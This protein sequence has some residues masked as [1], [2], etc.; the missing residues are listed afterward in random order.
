MLER[1]K[2]A[3]V[4]LL[5]ALLLPLTA[6]VGS[7]APAVESF[8]DL[9]GANAVYFYHL[10]SGRAMGSKNE[11]EKLPA[12]TS[13]RI[14]SGLIFCERLENQLSG[15]V[16]IT[17]DMIRGA[18]GYYGYGME[19]G[20]FFRIE[21]LLYLSLCG[22]YN[23]AYYALAYIIGAGDISAFVQMMNDRARELGAVNTTATDPS[24]ILDSS[25]TTAA[26]LLLI[27]QKTVENTLYM[28]I[29]GCPAYDLNGERRIEN[30]NALISSAQEA[31]RYYN[32]KCRGLTA[33]NT[34]LGGWTVVTMSEKEND[35]YLCIVL[36]GK[37]GQDERAEK[38]GY[39]IINRMIDWGYTNYRY[40]EVLTPET[41]VCKI[42]VRATDVADGAQLCVKESLSFYLPSD[43]VVGENVRFSI[44]LIHEELDAPVKAGTHVGYIA[45]IYDEEVLGT[46]ML[47]TAE[48]I[49]RS[50]FIGGLMNVKRLTESRAACAGLIFFC[51]AMLAWGIGEYLIKRAR[52][53]KWDRYFSEKIDAS[54]TFLTKK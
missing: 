1:V 23:D 45:V 41:E 34:T 10:E 20:D 13:L 46:A 19:A 49:G 54:E 7:A 50:G 24:G 48:D 37:V 4:V 22:G 3:A 17:D 15:T 21:Q 31:G 5:I 33:G 25:F 47:Y 32:S 52:R 16:E 14:L 8:P 6:F 27:A 44:R 28:Q 36:G 42:P 29:S 12:G 11:T 30:R 18:K 51:V 53:H 43:A 38:F 40:L 39:S 35:R 9:S 2:I 26:D